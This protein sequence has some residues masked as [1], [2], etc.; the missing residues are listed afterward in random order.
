M[1]CGLGLFVMY[2]S[3]MLNTSSVCCKNGSVSEFIFLKC[4]TLIF[5]MFNTGFFSIVARL[6]PAQ[7][8]NQMISYF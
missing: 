5:Q 2:G 6:I 1:F 3:P 8:Q 4:G 7:K